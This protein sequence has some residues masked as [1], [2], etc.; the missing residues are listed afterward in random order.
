M[1]GWYTIDFTFLDIL[2][3]LLYL[4][5]EGA[6]ELEILV[7]LLQVS[8]ITL[9]KPKQPQKKTK[10]KNSNTYPHQNPLEWNF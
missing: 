7:S 9:K 1:E 3:R 5:K 6:K 4:S 8:V 10:Q 2:I